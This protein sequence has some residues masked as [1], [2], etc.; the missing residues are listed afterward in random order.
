TLIDNDKFFARAVLKNSDGTYTTYPAWYVFDFKYD[1]QGSYQNSTMDRLNALSDVTGETYSKENVIRIEY[2]EFN[3][4]GLK[5]ARKSS[6]NNSSFPNAKYFRIPSHFT[7]V[8]FFNG[9]NVEIIDIAPEAKFTKIGKAALLNCY[10]LKE[11]ILPNT[12]TEIVAE[13]INFYNK[14]STSSLKVLNLGASLTTLGGKNAI[15]NCTIPGIRVIVPETLDG[16][17]YNYEYFPKTAV[18]LFTGTK[19]QAEK[20]GFDSEASGGAIM[21]YE[22]YVKNGYEADARTIVYGYSA[23]EAFY[24]G[25]HKT[26]ESQYAF[27]SLI[28]GSKDESVCTV[29]GNKT[30]IATYDPIMTFVGY[31]AK[32][33]GDKICVGYT[34]DKESLAVYEAKTGKTLAFGVTAAVVADGV[35]QYQP[36]NSDLSANGTAIV[37]EVDSEYVGFD[38]IL[39]GFTSAHYEKNLVMCAYVYDGSN[40]L[41]VDLGGCNEYATPFTFD[42]IAK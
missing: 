2:L 37:A 8:S 40:V 26:G 23:C 20:F 31:S 39:S 12:V 17:V 11:L 1:W 9:Y 27:T 15:G 25:E 32:I 29:C 3:E 38:F 35:V 6:D 18:V 34:I 30:T 5:L 13:G 33:D 22:D 28:E 21:S 19:E 14:Q 16:S 4:A 41:Y 36:V 10:S 7:S 42:S 24:K